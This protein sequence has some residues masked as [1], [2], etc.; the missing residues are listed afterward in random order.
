MEI[1][2]LFSCLPCSEQARSPSSQ[3][4]PKPLTEKLKEEMVQRYQSEAKPDPLPPRPAS[5][6][7]SPVRSLQLSQ[8]TPKSAT[9]NPSLSVSRRNQK[10][11]LVREDDYAYEMAMFYGEVQRR[12][13]LSA[14]V[15][16]KS[17]PFPESPKVALSRPF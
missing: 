12:D 6:A 3:A 5:I 2:W 4:G 8:S 13:T 1:N 7:N 15:I 11:S 16:L 14:S 9:P 10:K 17:T